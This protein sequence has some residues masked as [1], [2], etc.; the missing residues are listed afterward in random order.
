MRVGLIRVGRLRGFESCLFVVGFWEWRTLD[1]FHW[2]PKAL[3]E[4]PSKEVLKV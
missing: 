2:L 4:L 3:S 1:L